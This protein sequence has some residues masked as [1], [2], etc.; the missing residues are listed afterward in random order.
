M[1]GKTTQWYNPCLTT[2]FLF[3]SQKFR[4]FQFG[5]PTEFKH[6]SKVSLVFNCRKLF[7]I[8]LISWH[9]ICAS[10]PVFV[11]FGNPKVPPSSSSTVRA[12]IVAEGG[13]GRVNIKGMR[14]YYNFGIRS[15][16][17][18][19]LPRLSG[20]RNLRLGDDLSNPSGPLVVTFGYIVFTLFL[21]SIWWAP[22]RVSY[23][24]NSG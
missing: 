17:L 14:V 19:Y 8:N 5:W 18:L 16:K 12:K 10:E 20:T 9:N 6:P 3:Y 22:N 7:S 1:K 4:D 24:K 13:G 23:I 21:H 11:R 2:L 15:V